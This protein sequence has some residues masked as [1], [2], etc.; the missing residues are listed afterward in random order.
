MYNF[1]LLKM[2]YHKLFIS[3]INNLTLIITM[4][5]KVVD[6]NV[7]FGVLKSDELKPNVNI[8]QTDP[9]QVDFCM[10]LILEEMEELVE[11][12]NSNNYVET[13]DAL[14]DLPYVIMGMS[15]RIGMDLDKAFD[16]VHENNMSKL[17]KTEAEAQATV[18]HY[19]KNK[20]KLGYDTPAYRIAPD[21]IH[22]VVYNKSTNKILK[23]ICWKPVDLSGLCK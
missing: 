6:F 9:K 5:K 17:C 4:F 23:S 21:G 1:E 19:E 13:V 8:F 2:N 22:F 10:K 18:E 7:Q 3:N 20:E 16:L 11:A 14:A 12:V 15:A